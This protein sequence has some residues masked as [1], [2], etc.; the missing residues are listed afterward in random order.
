MKICLQK[1][2]LTRDEYIEALKSAD[3]G[4]YAPLIKLQGNLT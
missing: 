1:R 3:G 4:D 2:I